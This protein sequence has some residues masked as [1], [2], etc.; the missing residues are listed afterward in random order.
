MPNQTTNDL[1]SG[2]IPQEEATKIPK[3][4]QPHEAGGRSVDAVQ[5]LIRNFAKVGD[6]ITG[7]QA[8]EILADEIAFGEIEKTENDGADSI[9]L[10]TAGNAPYPAIETLSQ[11]YPDVTTLNDRV[12]E[13][14]SQDAKQRET[15]QVV[16]VRPMRKAEI[17]EIGAGLESMQE[18][19]GGMIEEIMP[20]DEEI[21]LICNEEGK[22]NGFELNRAIRCT[23]GRLMDIITGDF[24]ICSASGEDFI[25]LTDEQ[26]QRYCEMFKYPERFFQDMDGIHVVRIIPVKSA[27]MER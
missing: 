4:I 5:E 22:I 9:L 8:N 6:A 1:Y 15:M 25:G 20:F 27:V 17:V 16:L 12:G 14:F 7:N 24:F 21:C 11:H 2:N 26:A 10:S 18:T 19:V 3:N 13:Y 23:D